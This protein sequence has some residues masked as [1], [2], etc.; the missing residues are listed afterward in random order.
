MSNPTLLVVAALEIPIP[1]GTP[2]AIRFKGAVFQLILNTQI[3]IL[4]KN[5]K[6]IFVVAVSVLHL[7][8]RIY[9]ATND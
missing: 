5:V 4:E 2:F 7:E 3:N 1:K 9:D 8:N 6:S